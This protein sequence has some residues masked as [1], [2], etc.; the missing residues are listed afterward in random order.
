MRMSV[1][2]CTRYDETDGTCDPVSNMSVRSLVSTHKQHIVDRC[3]VWHERRDT[4]NAWSTGV[5]AVV[6]E[7]EWMREHKGDVSS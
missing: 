7:C 3:C 4:C 2:V 1:N 6:K 5:R